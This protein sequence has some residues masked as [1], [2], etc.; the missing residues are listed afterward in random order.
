VADIPTKVAGAMV[1]AIPVLI[2]FIIF[3]DRLMGN[4]SMG[5]LKE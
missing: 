3:K 1:L 2:F 5:G 4:I